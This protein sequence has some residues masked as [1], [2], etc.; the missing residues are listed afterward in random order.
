MGTCS[1]GD[2][3]ARLLALRGSGPQQ[4]TNGEQMLIP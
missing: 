4:Q 3:S 1:T 2:L